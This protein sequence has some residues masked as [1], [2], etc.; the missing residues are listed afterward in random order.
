MNHFISIW[1]PGPALLVRCKKV[2]PF[3]DITT[4]QIT[5]QLD[6]NLQGQKEQTGMDRRCYDME[7]GKRS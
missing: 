7:K 5:K 6:T 2:F 4:I 1:L 3:S